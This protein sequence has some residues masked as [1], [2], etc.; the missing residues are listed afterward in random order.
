MTNARQM[1]SPSDAK[2]VH[3]GRRL[4]VSYVLICVLVVG[5]AAWHLDESRKSA[6]QNATAANRNLA[7]TLQ[8]GIAETFARI[9]Y[10]LLVVADE[11]H[12]QY[13]A[14][15]PDDKEIEAFLERQALRVPGLYGFLIAD[16]DGALTHGRGVSGETTASIGQ[17][18]YF[19]HAR[20][21]P[22][23][24][25]IISEPVLGRL[26]ARPQIVLARRIN[27]ADGSFCGLVFAPIHLDQF[28][29]RF[30]NLDVGS[31]GL[32]VLRNKNSALLARY[33]ALPGELGKLGSVAISPEL[34]EIL[35][36]GLDEASYVAAS[37][38]D[39]IIRSYLYEAF[40]RTPLYVIV[41]LALDEYL[42]SWRKEAAYIAALVAIFLV[43]LGAACWKLHRSWVQR[44]VL[45]EEIRAL[46]F[47][48]SL[49]G[50]AN[51][52]LFADRLSQAALKSSRSQSHVALL[53]IDLDN[54]KDLNDT[55]GHAEGD[56]LLELVADRLATSLR[57][58][59]TVA[60]FGGDE[61]V[62]LLEDLGADYA[63]AAANAMVS[64]NK[65]RDA[66]NFP[67]KLLG[68]ASPG[69]H[70][71]PSI[72][73]ALFVGQS[74]SMDTVLDK[75]DKALY[76]AK[77]SGKNAICFPQAIGGDDPAV[78]VPQDDAS[79]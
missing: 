73:I 5:F 60:R 44:L 11:I 63:P 30:S 53:Y 75:A 71:S 29:E 77:K 39:G 48:D 67:Y 15:K 57:E 38:T 31:R 51:R 28:Q 70:C 43:L 79:R 72:G 9:D 3:F 7:K 21:N 42:A 55:L 20:D 23:S 61:F 33:P 58:G 46:A 47:Y 68:A 66:L 1:Q 8:Y 50:L 76:Q 36:A 22:D 16:R 35:A 27:C 62:V 18:E 54:F 24:E 34:K 37:P 13:A 74:E 6:L 78:H 19:V 17:R 26:T 45:E 56:R 52:N 49:T 14:R 64:A 69:W 2:A 59:D 12:K 32:I 40:S 41:G 10:G 25:L 65:I 4:A